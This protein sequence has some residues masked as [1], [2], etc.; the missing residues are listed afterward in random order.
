MPA[1]DEDVSAQVDVHVSSD[2]A[3]SP[4]K[5]R[6]S[7]I[8]GMFKGVVPG[9]KQ[10]MRRGSKLKARKSET[11]EDSEDGDVE[12]EGLHSETSGQDDG[13]DKNGHAVEPQGSE[14]QETSN[15]GGNKDESKLCSDREK[16]SDLP[17]V[18]DAPGLLEQSPRTIVPTNSMKPGAESDDTIGELVMLPNSICKIAE[19]DQPPPVEQ[20]GASKESREI[21]TDKQ[22]DLEMKQPHVSETG[23]I[24][25]KG[26]E[27]WFSKMK[28]VPQLQ[29]QHSDPTRGV[30]ESYITNRRKNP[31]SP[32]SASD[33]TSITPRE[34]DSAE[35]LNDLG[36]GLKI[37]LEL[38]YLTDKTVGESS[39]NSLS[40]LLKETAANEIVN[41]TGK[42]S[43]GDLTEQELEA[44]KVLAMSRRQQLRSMGGDAIK[45]FSRRS[46]Q[47]FGKK[48]LNL[49][50][51]ISRVTLLV[52]SSDK[53]IQCHAVR[54]ATSLV[55]KGAIVYAERL[56]NQKWLKLIIRIIENALYST[57]QDE[58]LSR[59][60]MYKEDSGLPDASLTGEDTGTS[61]S[62]SKED[63]K[64]LRISF[65]F[66]GA[67]KLGRFKTN[68]QKDPEFGKRLVADQ[69]KLIELLT[70]MCDRCPLLMQSPFTDHFKLLKS[71]FGALVGLIENLE[72]DQWGGEAA[73]TLVRV[74]LRKARE[75]A[76]Q[77]HVLSSDIVYRSL[78]SIDDDGF[79]QD[80]DIEEVPSPS[81][82]V[83]SVGMDGE[84]YYQTGRGP[85]IR[86]AQEGRNSSLSNASS[87][88]SFRCKGSHVLT[89][90]ADE[91]DEEIPANASRLAV[92][93]RRAQQA[94]QQLGK[95]YQFVSLTIEAL[96]VVRSA[97]VLSQS[98]AVYTAKAFEEHRVMDVLNLL[99]RAEVPGA[100]TNLAQF[101]LALCK[102]VDVRTKTL[103][104][105]YGVIVRLVRLASPSSM[106][107][108]KDSALY[109]ADEEAYEPAI[110][111]LTCLAEEDAIGT[112]I[113][114]AGGLGPIHFHA[115]SNRNTRK[116]AKEA[117][118]ALHVRNISDLVNLWT[119]YRKEVGVAKETI[120]VDEGPFDEPEPTTLDVASVPPLRRSQTPPPQMPSALQQ[121]GT[122]F[123]SRAFP[124]LTKNPGSSAGYHQSAQCNKL[125]HFH[126]SS[127][128]RTDKIRRDI[129]N[130]YRKDGHCLLMEEED[131]C[132]DESGGPW[133]TRTE[134]GNGAFS[135]VYKAF[136]K[137]ELT[138]AEDDSRESDSSESNCV[139]IPVA[140][141]KLTDAAFSDDN[142]VKEIKILS[143]V[144]PSRHI[145][146][147]H[148]V[149]L[150]D[151]SCLI[152]SELGGPRTLA[153]HLATQNEP[154]GKGRS[155]LCTSWV[156]RMKVLLNVA[157]ALKTLHEIQ[158]VHLDVKSSNI[159]ITE[160]DRG[161]FVPKLC[162]FGLAV[163]INRGME[164]LSPSNQGTLQWMAPEVM[165]DSEVELA[166]GFGIAADVFSFAV[167]M[168]EVAHP[169]EVPW[170][171]LSFDVN[172]TS[173]QDRIREQV[174]SRKRLQCKGTE[175]WPKG[176]FRLMRACWKHN[177]EERPSFL[178]SFL[179]DP[180][181]SQND[182][183]VAT[184]TISASLTRMLIYLK[185]EG[186]IQNGTECLNIR[187]RNCPYAGSGSRLK[188][189]GT[190]QVGL[191]S[192]AHASET[193]GGTQAPL[194]AAKRKNK[195]RRRSTFT[196]HNQINGTLAG[197]PDLDYSIR[198]IDVD[199]SHRGNSGS[200]GSSE[201]RETFTYRNPSSSV[202][203]LSSRHK[204]SFG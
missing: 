116:S 158:V 34:E 12:E 143:Q 85:Q 5:R 56:V 93:Q 101:L 149:V 63:T 186:R 6:L 132:G 191:E 37:A 53:S 8:S 200:L 107:S 14:K 51:V 21:G 100:R 25:A 195:C 57:T 17:T 137:K 39:D 45:Y 129:S 22:D 178:G 36:N 152:V 124:L 202:D 83:H 84:G 16:V 135:T 9:V 62:L 48:G 32:N 10:M 69:V 68:S 122:S 87:P 155:P 133:N 40:C 3:S 76:D 134:L 54:V 151:T 113:I 193:E 159:L 73:K 96:K 161:R 67:L 11:G 105:E 160:C 201:T 184:R 117:L 181:N 114:I 142:F 119:D 24:S 138:A 169:G 154:I 171:E 164:F 26:F 99:Y 2:D 41:D 77:C 198:D 43:F 188:H 88:A 192:D 145:T 18:S 95:K 35:N 38:L 13:N 128:T 20:L 44:L 166:K 78:N 110:R 170:N 103:L 136:M 23:K 42:M 66:L 182:V 144:P 86:N 187:I 168:W 81:S 94:Q 15:A 59:P 7:V 174:C 183:E 115:N 89:H 60:S 196:T 156:A 139:Y 162:D 108:K 130:L 74:A 109:C 90:G 125:R 91:L 70:K 189:T 102:S 47:K 203:D 80:Y 52:K 204:G 199:S 58:L 147:L 50:D 65:E 176:Y 121:G 127:L 46:R 177:P 61:F 75:A 97:C 194:S 148:G 4:N 98:I 163:E 30:L 165:H 118:E 131:L 82:A 123:V 31:P 173:L 140:V 106:Y 104:C 19:P 92:A 167:L 141:K 180:D 175:Q 179:T 64:L 157:Y 150:T 49:G 172:L 1:G 146:N 112:R 79:A 55:D 28:L 27:E 71:L 29:R 33:R 185:S 153:W 190:R 120:Q 197:N 126:S 72:E 111:A